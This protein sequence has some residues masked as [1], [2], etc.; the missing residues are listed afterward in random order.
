MRKS[1]Q[2]VPREVARYPP[3]EVLL[4][5]VRCGFFDW[6]C[7]LLMRREFSGH[8]CCPLSENVC[9]SARQR[10]FLCGAE[11]SQGRTAIQA[12]QVGPPAIRTGLHFKE[13][14]GSHV[15]RYVST[16]PSRVL[17]LRPCDYGQDR[18]RWIRMRRVLACIADGSI[19]AHNHGQG[20]VVMVERGCDDLP[21]KRVVG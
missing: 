8:G 4:A 3:F 21:L 18:S 9:R 5:N 15:A 14:D 20:L 13:L 10:F 1:A 16:E 11:P 2:S 7:S 17:L 6:T 19:I 12:V